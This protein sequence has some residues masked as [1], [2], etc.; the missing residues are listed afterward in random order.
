[1]VDAW[2]DLGHLHEATH[3]RWAMARALVAAGERERAAPIL[4]AAH[5][6]AWMLGAALLVHS[7]ERTSSRARLELVPAPGGQPAPIGPAL[8]ELTPREL[9]VLELLALARDNRQI[10]AALCISRKTASVHVSNIRA[11]LGVSNRLEAVVAAREL[12]LLRRR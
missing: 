11:K 3:A 10:A 2:Q 7:I 9:E 4:A 8:H 6:D 1:M 5:R 12:G